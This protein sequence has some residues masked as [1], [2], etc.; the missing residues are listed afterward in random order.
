MCEEMRRM[1]PTIGTATL[2]QAVLIGH[3]FGALLCLAF[4]VRNPG[5]V[6]GLVLV[7]PPSEWAHMDRQRAWLLRGGIQLSRLGAVLARLGIVRAC[8]ALLTGG[9][10][11]APRYFVKLFG[12]TTARTLERLVGEVRK[13]PPELHPV[14]QALWC[15]PK[16]FLAMAAYLG[17]LPEAIAEVGRV[18]PL[19]VPLIVISSGD[20]TPDVLE[21][22]QAL[23]RKSTMGRHVV[24]A[25]S[26]HWIPFDEPGL[27]VTAIR[28]VVQ[29]H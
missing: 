27:I 21:A 5:L 7:D 20:Q 16:C 19:T 17:A 29:K 14:V 6:R 12:P 3:S 10:P 26:T 22:H 8:L 28:D 4:T 15:Q 24:A 23:A 2:A 25:H 1:L 13:L 9:V 11:A 18:P